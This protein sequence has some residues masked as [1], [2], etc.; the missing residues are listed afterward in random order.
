M[1]NALLGLVACG[2]LFAAC[3]ST[4]EPAAA[5]ATHAKVVRVR[6]VKTSAPDGAK[7]IRL[8]VAG[9]EAGDSGG[10]STSAQSMRLMHLDGATL[11]LEGI[12]VEG[13]ELKLGESCESRIVTEGMK[14]DCAECP[15]G[16]EGVCEVICEV[17]D[18]D[19]AKSDT[20]NVEVWVNGRRVTPPAASPH[21]RPMLNGL[22]RG[23]V[24]AARLGQMREH[25]VQMTR[26]EHLGTAG[27][28]MRVDALR[29]SI[30]EMSNRLE[31]A[32]KALEVAESKAKEAGPKP[33]A[34]T[35]KKDG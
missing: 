6:T 26:G 1:K 11:N 28:K 24:A 32:E 18:A 15:E 10:S 34:A 3:S 13:S 30:E 17:Q 5:E 9:P 35:E 33:P 21:G 19:A 14:I 25:M 7:A 22:M 20:T 8:R 23:Q 12:K 29:R 27:A 2:L 16:A 4:T 31:E